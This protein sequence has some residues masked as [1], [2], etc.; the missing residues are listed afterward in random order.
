MSDQVLDWSA[1]RIAAE[2]RAGRLSPLD[3]LES[4]IA[5]LEAV[6]P[7]IN[8]VCERLYE[9]ARGTALAQ[10]ERLAKSR[11][12]LPA[13]FGVPC[14]IKE[15]FG[16]Q[17]QRRTAG[18]VHRRD[19]VSPRDATLVARLR[20]A[21]AIPMATTNVPELGF[22]FESENTIYGRTNNPY[23]FSRTSGGSS[24]GEGAVLGAG[25]SPLG[26][27]SDI[28]GSVRL[29]AA[30]CGI[31]GHK[32]S[33]LLLPIS[34]HFPYTDDDLP[35]LTGPKHPLTDP[36]FLVRRA[37]DLDLIFD[38]L[39]GP[40]GIDP[41]VRDLKTF[42]APPTDPRSLRVLVCASPE[43]H[44]CRATDPQ[45]SGA[46]QRTASLFEAYGARVEELNPRTFMRSAE[47]WGAAVRSTKEKR[48]EDALT[49]G[50]R[51]R[52]TKEFLLR[53]K[54]RS[55]YTL[56]ALMVA[57][58]ERFV[59]SGNQDHGPLLEEL[60]ELRQTMEALLDGNTILLMPVHPRP[61]FP[62]GDSWHTP[63][64]FLMTGILNAL[65]LPATACPVGR[66]SSGLP[67]SVQ[68]VAAAG[69]DSLCFQAARWIE[70]GFGGWSP[71]N[72]LS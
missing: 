12:D 55:V 72:Q 42:A 15:M 28:G 23:D 59:P 37:E 5:R 58:F 71:P 60:S 45:V 26:I 46:V 20:A 36:G 22:W 57:L 3:A 32:P 4:H 39:R 52:F 34:G 33:H 17:G 25:A 66:D 70:G 48:F 18:S 63:F 68:V 65:E 53:L 64:D 50:G 62:H 1:R 10:G 2:I 27:G 11:D 69:R 29:P 6:N 56:P 49:D 35:K 9:E 40:D 30:F 14:T 61:A 13:L 67:L 38:L 44:L 51:L 43:I 31:F 54:G 7:R 24:G 47:L 41:D 8:A 16:V 19:A 21:G